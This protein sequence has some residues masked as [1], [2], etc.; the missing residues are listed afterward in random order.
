MLARGSGLAKTQGFDI[1]VDEA[2]FLHRKITACH[3]TCKVVLGRPQ[4]LRLNVLLDCCNQVL[5]SQ[6]M[7]HVRGDEADGFMGGH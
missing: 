6:Y 7:H 1:G 4:F 3:V 2:C 5:L